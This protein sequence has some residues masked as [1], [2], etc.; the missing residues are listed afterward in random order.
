[1][2]TFEYTFASSTGTDDI[3]VKGWLPEGEPKAVIQY[4]HGVTSHIDKHSDEM[5][6]LCE[7]GYAVVGNDCLGHG[8]LAF[9]SGHLGW[10]AE[11]DG[12]LH[13]VN[14]FAS[15]YKQVKERFP[16]LKHV[17]YGNS[18]GSFV[19]RSFLIRF[20]GEKPDA[21]V[22]SATSMNTPELLRDSYKLIDELLSQGRDPKKGSSA[23]QRFA[24]GDYCARIE[25]PKSPFDWVCSDVERM[26]S[27]PGDGYSMFIMCPLLF[28][29]MTD[30]QAF[31]SE[32]ENIAKMR[33]DVPVYIV[34]GKDDPAGA[35]GEGPKK[36]A[37]AFKN[38]GVED[39]TLRLWE[40]ERHDLFQGFKGEQVM[41]EMVNWIET[42]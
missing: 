15:V 35:Y 24:F 11:K 31:N 20:P 2:K 16:G 42:K 9:E 41:T 39:V 40:G 36:V 27:R 23:I 18:M 13:V 8:K 7:R 34:S 10:F 30:G 28:R 25:N 37:Q 22:L 1:M 33:K 12:W 32:P 6:W 4:H 17:L 29:D 5:E 3:R 38:A 14:D 19:V 21:V 26:M